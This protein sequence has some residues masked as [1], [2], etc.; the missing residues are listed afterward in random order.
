MGLR[1]LG[2]T[3]FRASRL[4]GFGE[5]IFSLKRVTQLRSDLFHT[6]RHNSKRPKQA[7]QEADE[8]DQPIGFRA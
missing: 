2:L 8:A 6:S 3:G 5:E 4:T 1:R 7:Q